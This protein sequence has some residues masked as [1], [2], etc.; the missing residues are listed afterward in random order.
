[1]AFAKIMRKCRKHRGLSQEQLAEE[2]DVDQTYVSLVE[3][4]KRNPSID[5]ADRL[6]RA[7]GTKLS[8]LVEEA[9]RE[10]R[11]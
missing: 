7:L 3:R 5:I 9:E 8:L 6:A 1:M 10:A 11:R 2:A 4:G